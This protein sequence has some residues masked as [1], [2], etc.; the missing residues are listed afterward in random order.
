MERTRNKGEFFGSCNRSACLEP[1]ATYYNESTR[2]Y[3]CA[4]CAEKINTHN[5][6]FFLE[7]GRPL[8]TNRGDV[9]IDKNIDLDDMLEKTEP[10]NRARIRAAMRAL[11]GKRKYGYR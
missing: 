5:P 4:E 2:K 7:N 6:E 9:G 8:C 10:L 11:K 1:G 3:Y